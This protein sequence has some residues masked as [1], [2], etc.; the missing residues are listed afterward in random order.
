[1]GMEIW[2]L[3]DNVAVGL[4]FSHR[5]RIVK[6]YSR[7]HEHHGDSKA[8][9]Q[10]HGWRENRMPTCAPNGGLTIG[11]RNRRRDGYGGRDANRL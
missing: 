11:L 6:P 5:I 3:L 9:A 10:K 7:I 4:I 2:N 8:A 1:L